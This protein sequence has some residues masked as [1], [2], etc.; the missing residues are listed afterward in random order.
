MPKATRLK[1][2]STEQGISQ[3]ERRAAKVRG[4]DSTDEF[5]LST[6]KPA[7]L[8]SVSPITPSGGKI[9]RTLWMTFLYVLW[10]QLIPCRTASV[11]QLAALTERE[12]SR[13]RCAH[14]G[15]EPGMACS[16]G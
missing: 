4:T 5:I 3:R 15:P 11:S 7:A 6:D 14:C 2:T 8:S 16:A 1:A 10:P 12:I 9:S 13:A